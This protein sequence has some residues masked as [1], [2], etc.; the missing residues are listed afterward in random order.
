MRYRTLG[1]SGLTVSVVGLGGN[2][3]GRRL[4]RDGTRSV[5][6]AAL[7]AGITL[8]DT[9]DMYGDDGASEQLLGAALGKH[10]DAVVLATK[11][12]M[13]THGLVGPSWLPR[14]ARDYVVRA[15]EGSLRRLGTDHL[16][17]LQYHEPDGVTPIEE[18]LRAMTDLVDA[19]K[20]R[21]LGTSNMAAWQLIDAAWSA[22]RAGTARFVTTQSRYHLLDRSAEI[23]IAPAALHVGMRLL[24]YYPLANGLLSGKYTKGQPAPP[25]SR[26]ATREGWLT[27]AA[28]DRVDLLRAFADER[29]I[30]VLDVAVGG[31]AAQ[32]SVGS[33][34]A[35][36]MRP[37]QVVANAAAGTWVATVDDLAALDAIVAPGE[38]VVG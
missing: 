5:V 9:A 38:R 7:D 2:N 31:L 6:H 1:A 15:V 13:D 34:I 26:L 36:A 29:G 22:D 20:V 17:L 24:P 28:L 37:E 3:F 23:E 10:R 30:T 8:F 35:G 16:D 27:D 19:G 21:Y 33:V 12:G 32:P 14:G 25:G 18:T 11:F 4:D